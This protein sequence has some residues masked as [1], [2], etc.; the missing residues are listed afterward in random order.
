MP[1]PS[2][3]FLF[4]FLMMLFAI[5]IYVRARKNRSS[6]RYLTAVAYIYV[7]EIAFMY[8]L[9]V[10]IFSSQHLP[11]TYHETSN[12]KVFLDFF[13]VYQITILIFSR[14]LL[15][16]SNKPYRLYILMLKRADIML[17]KN[18]WNSLRAYSEKLKTKFPE[19]QFNKSMET[20]RRELYKA[21][22]LILQR[23]D[24]NN[25]K[26]KLLNELSQEELENYKSEQRK[27][28]DERWSLEKA[29]DEVREHVQLE[30]A[31]VELLLEEEE[32]HLSGSIALILIP[33][34]EGKLL[35]SKNK[36]VQKTKNIV[37]VIVNFSKS[38]R[39][40]IINLLLIVTLTLMLL[41]N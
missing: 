22:D 10:L 29:I 34:L 2:S 32:V 33:V 36:F 26:S 1:A 15:N 18:Q 38:Y 35:G 11:F 30:I 28:N 23:N 19:D 14:T 12:L 41:Y 17:A 3:I 37:D 4:T 8:F 6:Y 7:T 16:A 20:K 31:Q 21:I 24:L 27:K 40:I 25:Q 5:F 13:T 39:L 9:F